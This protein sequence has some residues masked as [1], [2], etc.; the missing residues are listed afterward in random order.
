MEIQNKYL[1]NDLEQIARDLVSG[2]K[3]DVPGYPNTSLL[4]QE[5]E[6]TLEQLR[7]LRDQEPDK[8]QFDG[9]S[10]PACH[11]ST[12]FMQM[13]YTPQYSEHSAYSHTRQPN[14]NKL[15][16]RPYAMETEQKRDPI[17]QEGREQELQQK[18]LSL[19]EKHKQSAAQK[20]GDYWTG[21]MAGA[22]S[23]SLMK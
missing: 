2:T 6:L 4:E 12:D 1:T 3:K 5:I 22:L 9:F 10:Q 16:S 14:C 8:P 15:Q 13:E 20:M 7:K 11:M 19:L 17:V 18:L 21:R 23:N